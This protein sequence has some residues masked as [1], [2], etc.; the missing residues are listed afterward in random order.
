MAGIKVIALDGVFSELSRL[1]GMEEGVMIPYNWVDKIPAITSVRCRQ[2][3][4]IIMSMEW[5]RLLMTSYFD[6]TSSEFMH[7]IKRLLAE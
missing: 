4:D 7:I 6:L 1:I 5:T 2:C 3:R